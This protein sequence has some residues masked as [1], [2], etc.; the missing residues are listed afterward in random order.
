M[1]SSN[2]PIVIVFGI[3]CLVYSVPTEPQSN[4]DLP[5]DNHP[6][7]ISQAIAPPIGHEHSISRRQEPGNLWHHTTPYELAILTAYSFYKFLEVLVNIHLWYRAYIAENKAYEALTT[8]SIG[9]FNYR[10]GCDKHPIPQ[11]LLIE[12][13]KKKRNEAEKGVIPVKETEWWTRGDGQ[14]CWI[15]Q[16]LI[17]GQAKKHRK[18]QEEKSD[19][20]SALVSQPGLSALPNWA[21]D[22]A[23]ALLS[24]KT[25]MSSDEA[26]PPSQ[27]SAKGKV[28]EQTPELAG[29]KESPIK[30]MAQAV[31]EMVKETKLGKAKDLLSVV[32]LSLKDTRDANDPDW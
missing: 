21:Q 20:A 5:P 14:M 24:G 15:K 17:P 31:S 13:V 7:T 4:K 12:Y 32:K 27:S 28:A 30:S 2:L 10:W 16:T 1:R 6:S 9:D 26:T 8:F 11:D 3:A 22:M 19:K 25:D 18:N 29:A 23:A